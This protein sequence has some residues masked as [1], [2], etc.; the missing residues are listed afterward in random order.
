MSLNSLYS[1]LASALSAAASAS[2]LMTCFTRFTLTCMP[3]RSELHICHM[4]M[5]ASAT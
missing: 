5:T 2:A 1:A 4:C 3:G